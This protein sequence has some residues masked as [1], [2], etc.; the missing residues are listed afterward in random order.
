MVKNRALH[1]SLNILS[2]QA[3]GRHLLS[4]LGLNFDSPCKTSLSQLFSLR[5]LPVVHAWW[6][7]RFDDIRIYHF[8]YFS[9]HGF[10]LKLWILWR[11]S[12]WGGESPVSMKS[13]TLCIPKKSSFPAANNFS[14]R[15]N[16]SWTWSFSTRE[17][18][19]SL[20]VKSWPIFCLSFEGWGSM[21]VD[22]VWETE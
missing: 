6:V 5:S 15:A 3:S 21:P 19:G 18:F 8:F 12:L 4:W 9:S 2:H 10:S 16:I 7:E 17:M 14:C 13:L 20:I 1:K 11:E 22:D